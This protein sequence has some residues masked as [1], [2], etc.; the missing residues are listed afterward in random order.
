MATRW[1]CLR[2]IVVLANSTWAGR[3]PI[4]GSSTV[5]GSQNYVS[6]SVRV[7][8]IFRDAVRGFLLLALGGLLLVEQFEIGVAESWGHGRSS[9]HRPPAARM[10]LGSRLAATG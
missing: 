2:K 5:T 6:N 4:L 9:S 10:K 3:G 7:R 1:S 8:R